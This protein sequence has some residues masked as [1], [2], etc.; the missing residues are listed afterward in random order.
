MRAEREDVTAKPPAT[1]APP[2]IGRRVWR[3]FRCLFRWCRLVVWF[4]LLLVLLGGLFLHHV[5][6]PEPVKVRVVAAPA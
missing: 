1:G 2:G 4:L 5:G 6:L 3:A